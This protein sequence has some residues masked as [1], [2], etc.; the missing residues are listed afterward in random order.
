[1]IPLL[2]EYDDSQ[3]LTSSQCA[4]IAGV[5]RRTIVTWIRGGKL[6]ARKFPGERGQYRVLF[7]DL[8]GVLER[9][10]VPTQ[11]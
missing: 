8:K 10:Y 9:E 11:Q 5:H 6:P 2:P 3:Q 1:M 7:R 4:D